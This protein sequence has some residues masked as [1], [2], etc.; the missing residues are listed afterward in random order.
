MADQDANPTIAG[1]PVND[2]ERWLAAI[3][4]S[5][6]DAIIGKTL[7]GKITSWNAGAERIFGYQADE[8]IGR[9]ITMLIPPELWPEEAEILG[10]LRRGE[11]IAHFETERL[12]KDGARIFIS[13]SISPVRGRN[14]DIVGIAKIARDITL[15][16]RL[17]SEAERVRAAELGEQRFREL[18]E[19]APDAILQVD[20]AGVITLANHSAETIFGYA[21]HELMGRTIEM[22]VPAG[23]RGSHAAHRE[24]FVAAGVARPMGQGLELNALR[25]D[26]TEFP[27]E[28]SLSPVRM[29]D[30]DVVI[31]VVRDVT[32]RKLAEKKIRLLQESYMTELE[33]RQHESERLNNLKSEFLASVSHELRT[34]L[35]TV[36]GFAALLDEEDEGP[37]NDVQK[38]FIQHIRE[39]ADHLLGLINDV[40][41]LSRIE[42]GGLKLQTTALEVLPL[43]RHVMDMAASSAAAKSIAIGLEEF[44]DAT[45]RADPLRVRQILDNLLSN[46]LKFTPAGGKVALRGRVHHGMLEV[47]VCDSGVGVSKEDQELIFGKFYQAGSTTTGVREGTGLGLAICRQ[48]VEMQGGEIRLESEVSRGSTFFFT[49]PLDSPVTRITQE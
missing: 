1:V 49:L 16:R 35:H 14:G 41:D 8:A 13:L 44:P 46:A 36:I 7:D 47:A 39:D 29:D 4:E 18:I 27:V 32:Q 40:L 45:V 48:L 2:P 12:R 28:I 26:G 24:S 37:L 31:A 11:R 38:R 30:G 9:S 5:S 33:M 19:H 20:R 3:V 43:V 6:D 22:L 23:S 10:R 15:Q 25:K 17:Q 42:A 21:H 34:P